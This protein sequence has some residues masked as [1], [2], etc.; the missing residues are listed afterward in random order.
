MQIADPDNN[1]L[2]IGSDPT[3][4]APPGEWLDMYGDRWITTPEGNSIKVTS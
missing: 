4:G 2:R 3:P 1:V